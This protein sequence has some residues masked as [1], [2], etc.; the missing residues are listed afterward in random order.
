MIERTFYPLAACQ[1]APERKGNTPPSLPQS[2]KM[3]RPMDCTSIGLPSSQFR[4]Q[5][6]APRRSF[7]MHEC[8]QGVRQPHCFSSL[9]QVPHWTQQWQIDHAHHPS[10]E[11]PDH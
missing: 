2:G 6:V 7:T 11:L 10:R 9:C 5:I 8:G 1:F 4:A 3:N